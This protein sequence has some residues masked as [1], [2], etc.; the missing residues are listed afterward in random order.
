MRNYLQLLLCLDH[1]NSLLCGIVGVDF[2]KVQHVQNRLARIVTKSPSFTRSVPLLCSLHWLPVKLR[3]SFKISLLIYKT[4]H[5]KQPL[6][7]IPCLP[8]PVHLDQA[9]ELVCQSLGSRPTQT[10]ELF[11]L[12]SHLSGTTCYCLSLQPFQLLP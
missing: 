2:T 7:F 6:I 8:H 3:I 1:C 9:K 4:L 11:T 12:V 10:Q 5:E